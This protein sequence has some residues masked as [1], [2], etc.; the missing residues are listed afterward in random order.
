MPSVVGT[1]PTNPTA[2]NACGPQFRKPPRALP[3][4]CQRLAR[5]QASPHSPLSMM[6]P[7]KSLA[8]KLAPARGLVDCGGMGQCG[9]N[10]FSYLLG[11][12][13]L[14][15]HDGPALRRHAVNY[16]RNTA[17]LDSPTWIVGPQGQLLTLREL[18]LHNF[19][20][21]PPEARQGR[22]VT[23]E[24]WQELETDPE[25]WT[26][27]AFFQ[28]VACAYQVAIHFI[29]VN[30]LSEFCDWKVLGPCDEAQPRGLLQVGLWTG[31]HMVGI[32]E[33][34][35]SPLAGD[36]AAQ[37]PP[38]PA[39]TEPTWFEAAAQAPIPL[40]VPPPPPPPAP[41]LP[42]A[43]LA[44]AL[45]PQA[46]GNQGA[47]ANAQGAHAVCASAASA[48][49]EAPGATS[50]NG[51]QATTPQQLRCAQAAMQSPAEV[52]A[53]LSES[54]HEDVY[55]VAF[56]FSG[57]VRD[58]LTALGRRAI[59]VDLRTSETPGPHYCGD[60]RDIVALAKWKCIYFFPPCYNH[61]RQDAD[62]L[63]LKIDDCRCFWAGAV[64]LWCLACPHAHSVVVEQSDTIVYDYIDLP[65]EFRTYEFRTAQCG[66]SPDKF[67]RLVT[68]LAQ[69]QLPPYHASAGPCE[70]PTHKEYKDA[71]ERDRARST[72]RNFHNTSAILAR[73]QM[74]VDDGLDD[75]YIRNVIVKP[76]TYD[77][78]IE[79]FAA[80]HHRDGHPVPEYYDALDAQPP[81]GDARKYS[82]QRGRGDLRRASVSARVVVPAS[83]AAGC[84]NALPSDLQHSQ[85][86]YAGHYQELPVED[87]DSESEDSFAR[88]TLSHPPNPIG[89]NTE[90]TAETTAEVEVMRPRSPKMNMEVETDEDD[91]SKESPATVDPSNF[92]L[93]L[94]VLMC[95]GV[96]G[97][98]LVLACADGY[99]TVGISM[100]AETAKTTLVRMQALVATLF[101]AVHVVYLVGR[102]AASGLWLYTAPVDFAPDPATVVRSPEERSRLRGSPRTAL[103][104]FTVAA[105]AGTAVGELGARA[106][107]S[108]RMFVT[109]V[110]LLSAATLSSVEGVKF[111]FGRHEATSLYTRTPDGP[112]TPGWR[113][114]EDMNAAD[115]LIVNSILSDVANGD[116]LLEGWAER[117]HPLDL[118]EIPRDYVDRLPSFDDK[119]LDLARLSPV[120]LPLVTPW[121]PL[122]P[123]QE[124]APP[125]APEC[126]TS[127]ADLLLPE[128]RARLS[129]WFEAA[130]LDL[131]S[132]HAQLEKGV[133]P[134]EVVRDR[135]QAEAIGEDEAQPWARG[136]VWDCS[137]KCC[138]VQQWSTPPSS[139]L[140]REFLK[141]RLEH[142]PDQAV[143]SY[144]LEGVRLEADVELQT[145]LVPHLTS[146]P[147][148]FASVHKELRRMRK[149]G[150][151]RFYAQLPYWPMYL[152]GQGAT[153]R[154]LEPD[155]WRRTTEGGG[156]RHP[157]YDNSGLRALSLND[158][159]LI[160]HMP[161]HFVRD[162]RPCFLE[163]LRQRGLPAPPPDPLV[164]TPKSKWAKEVKPLIVDLMRDVAVFRR[165]GHRL[166]VPVYSANDDIKDYFNQLAMARSERHKLGILFITQEGDVVGEDV[167]AAN[168]LVF[169]SELQLG[170][171]THPASNICQRIGDALLVLMR[172]EMDT[173][174]AELRATASAAELAWLEERLALQR[175]AG[176]P[177]T[178]IDEHTA[179]P[180]RQRP[181][182][183]APPRVADIPSGY[184][185]PQLRLYAV[186]IYSDDMQATAAGVERTKHMLRAWRRVVKQVRLIM[187]IEEKRSLGSWSTWLGVIVAA[188]LGAF[189][190]PKAKLLRALTAIDDAL[191]GTS[192]FGT[193]RSLCGLLEHLRAINLQGRHVMHGLYSP[194]GPEGASREGP[195]GPIVCTPLMIKQLRRWRGLVVRSGGVSA[196][197]AVHRHEVEA[198]PSLYIDVTSDAC[199]ADVE[200][201][202]IGG[203]LH[204]YYWFFEVPQAD[205]PLLNIQILEFLGPCLNILTFAATL[206]AATAADEGTK[207]LMRTDSLTTALTLTKESM[208]APTLVA[209][210]QWLRERPEWEQIARSVLVAHLSGDANPMADLIS[211]QR[212]EE[213][214]RLCA[215]VG[216]RPQ[217]VPLPPAVQELYDLIMAEL[218]ASA[219]AQ[220]HN[221]RPTAPPPTGQSSE[222]PSPGVRLPV[223][224][225]GPAPISDGAPGREQPSANFGCPP[226]PS[227]SSRPTG[228]SCATR[229]GMLPHMSAPCSPLDRMRAARGLPM[230][231]GERR[232]VPVA[233]Q[234][235][236]SPL[237]PLTPI[238]RL[239][240]ARSAVAGAGGMRPAAAPEAKTARLTTS[241]SPRGS[242]RL[243]PPPPAPASTPRQ[244]AGQSYARARAMALTAGDHSQAFRAE[245]AAAITSCA[246]AVEAAVEFG[247][248][249]NTARKDD[250]AWLFW[251]AVCEA[252]GTSPM[253]TAED[254]RLFPER[255]A[256]L[257]AALMLHAFAV[258]HPRD[259]TRAFI[260]PRSA[261]A[262]PLAIIRTFARWGV[263]MP[264]Y[265]MLKAVMG[266]LCRQYLDYHG[267][268]S[269][270]PRRSEFMKF[271]TVRR[272]DA[273]PVTPNEA[274]QLLCI[275]GLLWSD[276]THDVFT[277]RRLNRFMIVT[278]FRLGEIVR[279][280]S[281]EIMYITFDSV[282]WR[283]NGRMI[284]SPTLAELQSLVSGRD[285]AFVAPPRSKPDQWGE[286][287]CPFPVVLTFDAADPVNAAAALRDLELRRLRSEVPWPRDTT[288][289]F[290]T[291][292]GQPYT[293]HRLH[294]LL[295]AAL[296]HLYGALVA[297][298]YSW[299]SYRSGLATAL[300]ASGVSD[301]MVQ[302]ICR[303]MCPESLHV[304]R[305]MG[306]GEHERLIRGAQH[307]VVDG[308]QATNA[309]RVLADQGYAQLF[310]HVS[311]A[312][313]ALTATAADAF[314]AAQVGEDRDATLDP[315]FHLR[316]TA[317]GPPEPPA[318]P[319]PRAAP[320]ART[321]PLPQPIDEPAAPPRER[322]LVPAAIWPDYP[323]D[324][325]GGLGWDAEVVSASATT[326]LIE[327]TN[328]RSADRRQFQRVRLTRASLRPPIVGPSSASALAQE[329]IEHP[330]WSDGMIPFQGGRTWRFCHHWGQPGHER[331]TR[332]QD[333][334]QPPIILPADAVVAVDDPGDEAV[335]VVDHDVHPTVDSAPTTSH[336]DRCFVCLEG[337]HAG[338]LRSLRCCAGKV[339]EECM[340]TLIQSTAY[341]DGGSDDETS[342]SRE[343]GARCGLCNQRLR[344]L[345][346]ARLF[347]PIIGPSAASAPNY[348]VA[349][350]GPSSSSAL[351]QEVIEH[352]ATR[353]EE[354]TCP[355]FPFT[356]HVKWSR[357]P[358]HPAMPAF[359]G[360]DGRPITTGCIFI[361]YYATDHLPIGTTRHPLP[362][363]IPSAIDAGVRPPR[364]P[365]EPPPQ[366]FPLL[367]DPYY[368]VPSMTATCMADEIAAIIRMYHWRP[369]FPVHD[370]IERNLQSAVERQPFGVTS[371]QYAA[372]RS[373]YQ[374]ANA[375][376]QLFRCLPKRALV[377]PLP[378]DQRIVGRMV[379]LRALILAE[380]PLFD[381]LSASHPSYR[382]NRQPTT[383]PLVALDERPVLFNGQHCR[384]LRT[385][386][387]LLGA[388][389]SGAM[390]NYCPQR[391]LHFGPGAPH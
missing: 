281:G 128:G 315:T 342:G 31:R 89:T 238:D 56:E 364:W 208:K 55:L 344:R 330:H 75:T 5:A 254:A 157:T 153:A 345:T 273:I 20:H 59:S 204:G 350:I 69:L 259:T 251:V 337:A 376:L 18:I 391:Q 140:D 13:N 382:L 122:P 77:T 328:A 371:L 354:P 108:A 263:T 200:R 175:V 287:H 37:P 372:W 142:F 221:T 109:P 51:S 152:N 71:E 155:R 85:N 161:L 272:L 218:R 343:S 216:A 14:T 205:R 289:L 311:H 195:N 72:W 252:H 120:R 331:T 360:P 38:R 10:T 61:L 332:V 361:P 30:D 46:A 15:S 312:T 203:Y 186:R 193:Y 52:K 148:G 261:L 84:A 24:A 32:V 70:R 244:Q 327:F 12:L 43:P 231:E 194:H 353:S 389:T 173:I 125:E 359:S 19:E 54:N 171:G 63:Q 212:W 192:T 16:T 170:F 154:R 211:R 333:H 288:A 123:E 44:P 48:P 95:I 357:Q 82:Q 269:L 363:K 62:C 239:F 117:P 385:Q 297:M 126:P 111:S 98:P 7:L 266:G 96:L 29:A 373:L 39:G 133:P 41:Q 3:L 356:T 135:P 45:P 138:V 303:W 336:E 137:G 279:H 66:D 88:P 73:A 92:A 286:I 113:G 232:P 324:E 300:H 257:L 132:I 150:W 234:P 209:I 299:H 176:E 210:Y 317:A 167:V 28:A 184:V 215:Q 302:L 47:T 309:P 290:C 271:D 68:R 383:E 53:W 291:A 346:R 172:E 349:L 104:W 223:S 141:S 101:T 227:D 164:P 276:G 147:M 182:I 275:R 114:L 110:S 253:R 260:K 255:N 127:V 249:A 190:V 100:S 241:T 185:C 198:P 369:V 316:A 134:E 245:V 187:A 107:L 323:C 217:Q 87:S 240:L 305:R 202:G 102:Y 351:A 264:G 58:A 237:T 162:Q 115:A 80:N 352:M 334:A 366:R 26:D 377:H 179:G 78:L 86:F 118:D 160:H 6:P 370:R 149:L 375:V 156:P 34:A 220:P 298:L 387:A 197:R 94:A 40:L 274:G 358:V 158:A 106:V 181:P 341:A 65:P 367:A 90:T 277:F 258:C 267:P 250:R 99:H 8:Q 174:E 213:F 362:L 313:A 57:A 262:Y 169:I 390:C 180:E 304:Y 136:R 130:V 9:P 21:W 355:E 67:V 284:R 325:N 121:V 188:G 283:I 381:L 129:A 338:L 81:D 235:P 116:T 93:P 229:V 388:P 246:D 27:L 335:A 143:V 196:I 25:T 326:A 4:D 339:H 247:I 60:V 79:Q 168:Q 226:G 207:I 91:D 35:S 163:W 242:L 97:E 74:G 42:L 374:R 17:A 365:T 225:T 380:A 103:R 214:F 189:F 314:A 280:T 144:L 230:E 49:A 310:S 321:R 165:A 296:A 119:R 306:T 151:Y 347:E 320:T 278:A 64:V 145:V 348:E 285:A 248:N 222:A 183:P 11:L 386:M 384:L 322:V 22:A 112:T 124:P 256:H 76:S 307:V 319:N 191:A 201:A 33:V 139:H 379:W 270:A 131:Q 301:E 294:D 23:V 243:P 308:I 329:V 368:E 199:Y 166:G 105:L 219:A 295:R 293:H 146:L 36:P 206:S 1:L 378:E 159:S 177:C 236:N 224:P 50:R 233:S 2:G 228:G 282:T 268:M 292:E 318:L 265:K 340:M 83:C 178:P